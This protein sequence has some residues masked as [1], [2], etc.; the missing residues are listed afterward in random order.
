MQEL[1]EKAKAVGEA[2]DR[3]VDEGYVKLGALRIATI[4]WHISGVRWEP[5]KGIFSIQTVL[6]IIR[7]Y[8]W[9]S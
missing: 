4:H 6:A 3:D 2:A 7:V 8:L 9:K 5:A 1:W